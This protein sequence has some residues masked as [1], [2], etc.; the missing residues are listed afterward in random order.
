MKR[1]IV[2]GEPIAGEFFTNAH[3]GTFC[4]KD[5]MVRCWN[6]WKY[7]LV[8]AC[9][10]L[11]YKIFGS[12]SFYD[13]GICK[14]SLVLISEVACS[15]TSPSPSPSQS[16]ITTTTKKGHKSGAN[17]PLWWY[18]W[19]SLQGWQQRWQNYWHCYQRWHAFGWNLSQAN[20]KFYT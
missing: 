1:C 15:R 6:L 19:K 20:T 13:V 17:G 11:F 18:R 7:A 4:T 10:I 16:S 8:H 5:Y 12:A 9:F 3:G 14:C 2:C